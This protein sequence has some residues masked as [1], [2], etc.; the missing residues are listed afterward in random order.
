MD[1]FGEHSRKDRREID[2]CRRSDRIDLQISE[3]GRPRKVSR[4][5]L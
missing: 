3:L 4:T 2:V 5:Q 1:G